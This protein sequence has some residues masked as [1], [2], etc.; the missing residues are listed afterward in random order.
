MIDASQNCLIEL[1]FS[2]SV[3]YGDPFNEVDFKAVFVD[4]DG[5]E[6]RV[7]GFW[8]GGNTWK[9]RYSSSKI[10]MHRYWTHCSDAMNSGLHLN[11]G[12]ILVQPYQGDNRLF[13]HGALKK[14]SNSRFL[15][16]ED[17]T[18]FFW[19]GD[20]W[21]MGFT[22]RLSW[23]EDFQLLTADRVRKGFT[24][25]QIVAGLYPDMD[26]F[27]ERGANEAGFP[28]DKEYRSVN[29]AILT[30]PIGNR[31]A[32]RCRSSSVHRRLLGILYSP[33]GNRSDQEALGIHPGQIR[34]L[35]GC[36]VPGGRSSR[37]FL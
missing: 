11:E 30:W 9:I 12:E 7:P 3:V 29:P 27:D 6:K 35:S 17:G 23:P 2:S 19:L 24:V 1:S 13:L 21:W 34:S 16:H 36:L 5:T 14:S 32:C 25:I 8:S 10:G 4:P 33:G 15:E 20:T 18:P 28:W 22:S 26:P 37:A 31:R